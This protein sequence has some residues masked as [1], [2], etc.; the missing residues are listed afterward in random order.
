MR[1]PRVLDLIAPA[2]DDTLVATPVSTR[3]NSVRN[4]DPA[5]LLPVE[6]QRR[7]S[8]AQPVLTTA[9]ETPPERKRPPYVLGTEEEAHARHRL[10]SDPPTVRRREPLPPG[11]RLR[12]LRGRRRRRGARLQGDRGELPRSD[13]QRSPRRRGG[14]R[15]GLHR[16]RVRPAQ[17]QHLPAL[18]PAEGRPDPRARL[19][20][21]PSPSPR[22]RPGSG[23]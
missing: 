12:R 7:G 6:R 21:R 19:R 22:P 13:R 9:R 14:R 17:R 11:R 4:D 15:P 10:R 5:C 20:G 18:L 1:R 2:P 16:L 23:W 3:V 8:T